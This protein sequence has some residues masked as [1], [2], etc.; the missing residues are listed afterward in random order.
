MK[1][2]I[3]LAIVIG[4]NLPLFA[5]PSFFSWQRPTTGENKGNNY[6]SFPQDQGEQGPCHIFAAVAAIEAISHIY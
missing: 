3:T 6:I 5:Q 4:N 1:K 2:F